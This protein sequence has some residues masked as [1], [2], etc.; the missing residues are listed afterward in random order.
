MAPIIFH[1][2]IVSESLTS[3]LGWVVCKDRRDCLRAYH[4]RLG[5]TGGEGMGRGKGHN[6]LDGFGI[7]FHFGSHTPSL[8][9]S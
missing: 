6:G 8:V 2:S 1:L 3:R 9:W 5:G 4:L 7:V